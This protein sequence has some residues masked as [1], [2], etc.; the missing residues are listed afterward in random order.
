MKLPKIFIPENNLENGLEKILNKKVHI[1]KFEI[2]YPHAYYTDT[3]AKYIAKL[4]EQGRKPFTFFENVEARISD[5]EANGENA[6]L[7]KTWL[8]SVTGIA[9]KAYNTKFKLI[10]RSD[11]LENIDFNQSF[12][13]IDYDTE[14]GI[15][16]DSTK[17]KYDQDLTREEA[18][19]HEFWLAVMNGDKEKLDRYVDILFD[20]T[21]KKEGMGIYLTG[22]YRDELRALTLNDDY[23]NSE[24][25]D[26]NYLFSNPRF[27][28]NAQ[29]S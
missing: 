26:H 25:S 6:E 27:I 11:K 17:G 21:G 2:I 3:Y 5:Y 22:G 16:L 8:S 14:Q 29:Y 20:K 28:S 7:F 15:E 4:K 1:T 23:L 9:Y 18:K 13:P 24:A 19:N 12:I 10:L